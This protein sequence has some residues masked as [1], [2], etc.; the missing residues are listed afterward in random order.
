MNPLSTEGW[1][2]GPKILHQPQYDKNTVPSQKQ[3]ERKDAD[4]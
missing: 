3:E 4:A 2:A 1:T